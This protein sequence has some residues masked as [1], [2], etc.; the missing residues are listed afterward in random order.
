[1]AH[2]LENAASMEREHLSLVTV[3]FQF[4]DKAFGM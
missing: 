2:T 4:D 3:M 1:M